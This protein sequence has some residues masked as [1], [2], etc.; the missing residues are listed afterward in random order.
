VFLILAFPSVG[1]SSGAPGARAPASSGTLTHPPAPLLPPS[2][3]ISVPRGFDG[4]LPNGSFQV[5]PYL[6]YSSE[7]APMG[8][9]DYGVDTNGRTYSYSTDMFV[10]SARVSS[11]SMYSSGSGYQG[12]LQ[13]NVVLWFTSGSAT[14]AYWIQDV[15]FMDTS[16]NT[17]EFE[18]NIWNF[19]EDNSAGMIS[20]T[21]TGNGSV[22][23]YGPL[24]YYAAGAGSQA[25]NGYS[26]TYPATVELRVR[27][28]L[29]SGVPRVYFDFDDGY[30][31]Q[32][33]DTAEFTFTNAATS[34]LFRVD[35]SNYVGIY[36]ESG[37]FQD[38]YSNAEL[39]FGGPGGGLGTSLTGANVNL[40]LQ[41]DNG[42]NLQT[43]VN[44]F[45]FGSDT[46][47]AINEAVASAAVREPTGALLSHLVYGTNGSLSNEYDRSYS[48][49][50]NGSTDLANGSYAINGTVIGPY[51]DN[52]VNITFA[53]GNYS[54]VLSSLGKPSEVANVTLTAGEYLAYNFNPPPK[55]H[56]NFESTGLPAGTPWAVMFDGVQEFTSSSSLTFQDT[57]GTYP[58]TVG[59]VSGY[60][61]N[62]THGTVMVDGAEVNVT[63]GWTEM[64]YG[65]NVSEIGLPARTNWSIVIGSDVYASQVPWLNITLPNGSYSYSVGLVSGYHPTISSGPISIHGLDVGI[66]VPFTIVTYVAQFSETGLPSGSP[67]ILNLA[68]TNYSSTSPSF[69]FNLPNGTYSFAVYTSVPYAPTPPNGSLLISGGKSSL[70]VAFTVLPG[71]LHGTVGPGAPTMLIG[72]HSVVVVNGTYSASLPPGSYTVYVTAPG[73]EP[74]RKNLT[75]S[76]GELL[77]LDIRL[78]PVPPPP[79][80]NNQSGGWEST[81]LFPLVVG[82]ALVAVAAAVG[83]V[84]YRR[85]RTSP[86]PT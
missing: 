11:L 86:P 47:E 4:K 12:T 13:L 82:I 54:I 58:F 71:T 36:G 31:W 27:S 50:F 41:Y 64:F 35:G 76:P 69:T 81:Y 78:T 65:V 73:Y 3:V 38:L 39:G 16:T 68:G 32:T 10:G 59:F 72:N 25:G 46:A 24:G 57:N 18:D 79:H 77:L 44:A 70:F 20:S 61:P 43:I 74:Y 83:L 84:L 14:F 7:P 85:R 45:N 19:T 23:P 34:A 51:R 30:G 42:H 22:S 33:Y 53:P 60:H 9:A 6:Y 21:V 1:F 5:D 67:W 17:W 75:L 49:I 80:Y 62:E 15:A 55:F 26:L 63:L 37:S 52:E 56:V 48:A 40:S 29:F 8:I 28:A 66:L 2:R